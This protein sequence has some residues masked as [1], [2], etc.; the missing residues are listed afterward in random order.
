MKDT[1]KRVRATAKCASFDIE[2]TATI[3]THGL[4]NAEADDVKRKLK[5]QLAAS[6]AALPFAHVYPGEVR[7]R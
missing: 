6:V 5:H 1:T 3:K 2:I 7:V 4:A